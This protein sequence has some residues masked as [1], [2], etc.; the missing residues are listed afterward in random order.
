MVGAAATL[1]E[2]EDRRVTVLCGADV[3]DRVDHR[4]ERGMHTRL[5][6][7][8]DA[9]PSARTFARA[10]INNRTTRK[11]EP[12]CTHAWG[13]SGRMCVSCNARQPPTRAPLQRRAVG[14]H[15]QIGWV[16][17]RSSRNGRER[18]WVEEGMGL[19]GSEPKWEFH[20]SWCSLSSQAWKATSSLNVALLYTCTE[21]IQRLL[22]GI[23][24]AQITRALHV[25][26][27]TRYNR[28]RRRPTAQSLGTPAG[29]SLRDHA[30]SRLSALPA[31]LR[32]VYAVSRRKL[33]PLWP[34]PTR[35][36]TRRTGCDA[37]PPPRAHRTPRAASSAAPRAAAPRRRAAGLHGRT[38]GREGGR[39]ACMR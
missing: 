14:T 24:S 37:R 22:D 26:R 2:P 5:T 1:C 38:G 23:G 25:A 29:L 31:T 34:Q 21:R 9:V 3:E 15:P 12:A 30:I 13:R 16:P 4:N 8:I 7:H 39:R 27:C 28:R 33:R 36:A 10:H 35:P 18:Q 19:S 11:H 6:L 20:R 17:A 32:Q